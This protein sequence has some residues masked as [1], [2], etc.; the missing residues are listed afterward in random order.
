MNEKRS[1]LEHL[2]SDMSRD[3]LQAVLFK[4]TEHDVI[5]S[6]RIGIV[7]ASYKQCSSNSLNTTLR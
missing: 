6:R 3:Q 4:L 2:L 5:E 1:G 7:L